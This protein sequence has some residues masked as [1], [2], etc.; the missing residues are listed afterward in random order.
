LRPKKIQNYKE[1]LEGDEMTKKTIED[2]YNEIKKKKL[3]D[4]DDDDYVMLES[5]KSSDSDNDAGDDDDWR[6]KPALS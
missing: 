4:G 2:E 3:E 1:L 6:K 5:G